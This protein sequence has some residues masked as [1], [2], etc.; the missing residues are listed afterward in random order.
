[1]I[2]WAL[3]RGQGRW[4]TLTPCRLF[5]ERWCNAMNRWSQA[6]RWSP[7]S[8]GAVRLQLPI[9]QLQVPQ[10]NAVV[11]TIPSILPDSIASELG[12]LD[13][14][15][16]GVSCGAQLSNSIVQLC[17]GESLVIYRHG[18]KGMCASKE[19][20]GGDVRPAFLAGRSS[21]ERGQ[22]ACRPNAGS[23]GGGTHC[24]S[25]S[26]ITAGDGRKKSK[27]NLKAP[28]MSAGYWVG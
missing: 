27:S 24:R 9:D 28:A 6:V 5:C 22:A 1:M 19:T 8:C 26:I 13:N 7:S 23:A 20:E 18:M 10:S 4:S 3:R 17:A 16:G 21:G 14:G 12:R 2:G 25:T 15:S 11:S